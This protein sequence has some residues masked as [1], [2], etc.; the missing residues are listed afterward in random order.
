MV[1]GVRLNARRAEVIDPTDGADD[2]F[3]PTA[4]GRSM[5]SW[6]SQRSASMPGRAYFAGDTWQSAVIEWSDS[7]QLIV[8]VAGPTHW[9]RWEF[10]AIL[11]R[12][13]WPKPTVL[14]PPSIQ[15]DNA[16]RWGNVVA[17]LQ[18]TPWR[19]DSGTD[20]GACRVDYAVIRKADV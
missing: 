2:L 3:L 16:A 4:A 6:K 17:E 20:L 7:A 14:M 9:I 1:P 5:P 13:A 8:M 10:D 15:D 19:R 18:D 11:D 12:N